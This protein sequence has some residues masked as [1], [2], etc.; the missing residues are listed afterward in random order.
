M[1]AGKEGAMFRPIKAG[2]VA[3][4]LCFW[5]SAIG[6]TTASNLNTLSWDGTIQ[7]GIAM[8]ELEAHLWAVGVATRRR[9]G[10]LTYS[11]SIATQKGTISSAMT[12]CIR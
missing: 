9:S 2:T 12:D 8:A 1:S 3:L 4:G 6:E 7:P 10:G 5:F 11:S